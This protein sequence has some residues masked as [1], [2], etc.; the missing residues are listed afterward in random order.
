MKSS[1]A[2]ALASPAGRQSEG[3]EPSKEKVR[4]ELGLEAP[5]GV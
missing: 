2:E 1:I 5:I 4:F 3:E